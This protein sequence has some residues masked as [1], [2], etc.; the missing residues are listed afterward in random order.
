MS[1]RSDLRRRRLA[2]ALSSCLA[3]AAAS[4]CT[5]TRTD[6][7]SC[8][9]NSECRTAFGV[10]RVCDTGTGLCAAAPFKPRCTTTYPDDLLTRPENY[11]GVIIVGSLMD[12]AVASQGARE[13]A[14]RLAATQVDELGGVDGHPFGV[15]FCDVGENAKYDSL[16]RTDAARDSALHLA[17]VVGVSAIVGPSSSTDALAVYDALDK[18]PNSRDVLVISPAATSPQLTGYDVSPASDDVPGLLWRTAPPDTLQGKAI[19]Q[20]IRSAFPTVAAVAVVAEKGAYGDALTT[21]FTAGFAQDGRTVQPFSY[22][23]TSERDAA[24]VSA[25]GT[26]AKIVLFISSQSADGIAFLNVANS[27]PAYAQTNLFLTDTAANS[28]LL[29]GAAGASALFSRVSGSRPAVPQ[30]PT[31]ELFKISF[32][33]AFKQDP[34]LFSFVPHA[35]DAAW[36]AFYG[37]ARAL[38][39][40]KRESGVSIARGLRA[41]SDKSTEIAVAPASWTRIIDALGAG[42]TVNLVGASGPLDYDLAT[43][44]TTGLVDIWK[45]SADG[46]AIVTDVTLDPAK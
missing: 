7:A 1:A 35:Y 15:V 42:G 29:T 33:A 19:V 27:L 28:D 16:N 43:E 44:E 31:F 9:Q 14:I 37:S 20:Q 26:G 24:I 13:N 45:I 2:L 36:L 23:N 17:S 22:S 4:S 25:G 6:V 11:P 39:R 8:T 34:N 3:L 10:G 5:L 41:L 46:K 12:R 38:R 40:D 18:A 32:T 21:V 30:G